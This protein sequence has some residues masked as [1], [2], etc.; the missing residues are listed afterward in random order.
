V[1]TSADLHEWHTRLRA[2]QRIIQLQHVVEI[3]SGPRRTGEEGVEIGLLADEGSAETG[4]ERMGDI[5][6]LVGDMNALTEGDYTRQE[7]QV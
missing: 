4:R 7:W 5:D 2:A 1:R 3:L 6:I